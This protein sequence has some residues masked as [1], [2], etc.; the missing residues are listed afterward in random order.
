MIKLKFANILD[1]LNAE[2]N[3]L[4][5]LSINNDYKD[6][7][8]EIKN[9]V[10]DIIKAIEIMQSYEE[11]RELPCVKSGNYHIWRADSCDGKHEDRF[12]IRQWGDEE[13]NDRTYP[14]CDLRTNCYIKAKE[15]AA[16]L[17]FKIS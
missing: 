7:I 17:G 9:C 3:E 11:N 16:K 14:V 13:I 15:L 10:S 2:L 4:K 1:D 6:D 8:L 12:L 5:E